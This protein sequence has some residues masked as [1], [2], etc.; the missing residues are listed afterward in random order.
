MY[1]LGWI[2]QEGK[3]FDNSY[4]IDSLLIA[5]K[6]SMACYL[7]TG[8]KK[9][10]LVDASGKMEGKT[11]AKKLLKMNISPD[12]LILTHSHW[13]HAF[14]TLKI[15]KAFPDIEIM[16]SH[17]G[18]ESL[19]NPN[20]F[21]A[22]FSDITSKLRPIENVTPL[23]ENEVIDIGDNEL[24]I[25]ETPGHTNCSISIMDERNKNLFVGDGMGYVMLGV[26][27]LAPIM[28]PEFS[29]KN[30]LSTIEKVRNIDYKSITPAHYGC[31][32]EEDAKN[33]P[34]KTEKYYYEWRDFLI[35][36]WKE[37]PDE[38]YIYEEMAKKIQ[39]LGLTDTQATGYSEL[40]GDWYIKG[41]KA[42]NML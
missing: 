26:V 33:F 21:N 23:K 3:F 19:K 12:I 20:E 24:R 17:L 37:K 1:D 2:K 4:I 42:A 25:I 41:L 38:H 7:V 32:T 29:E 40:F 14:G 30:L 10:V 15:K 34:E 13:D 22:A 27:F 36:K 9:N 5:Q 31:F 6:E 35:S 8:T 16:A 11:V 28:A 39:P 18:I